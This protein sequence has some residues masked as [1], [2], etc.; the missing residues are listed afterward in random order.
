MKEIFPVL[1][2]MTSS[3]GY[4]RVD[5]IVAAILNLSR[6]EIRFEGRCPCIRKVIAT[7]D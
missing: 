6:V 7:T 3:I 4:N 1:K 2:S 5:V